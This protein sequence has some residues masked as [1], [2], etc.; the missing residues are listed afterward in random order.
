M[1][2]KGE[3]G[4]TQGAMILISVSSNGFSND[5]GPGVHELC[6]SSLRRDN[7]KLPWWQLDKNKMLT[8]SGDQG[9][10][11]EVHQKGRTVLLRG[12]LQG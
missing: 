2:G 11:E 1:G 8:E 6:A 7:C 9:M 10:E 3:D 5:R 4:D 12:T